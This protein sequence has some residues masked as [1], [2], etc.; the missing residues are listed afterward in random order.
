[1]SPF[2]VII[3]GGGLA[4]SL[5][6]NGLL[7]NGVEVAVYERDAA[8][9]KREGYQIRLGDA[10]DVG[11]KACLKDDVRAAILAKFGQSSGAGNTAPT[12]CNSRFETVLDL[13]QL[14]SYTKSSAINRVAL[15]NILLEPIKTA[16]CVKFQKRLDMYNIVSDEQGNEHVQVRFSDGSTDTCD[17][18]VAADGSGSNVSEISTARVENIVEVD[19]H[20]MFL[21]KGDLTEG[22][23]TKLPSRLRTGPVLTFTKDMTFFFALYLPVAQEQGSKGSSECAYDL[24]RGSFYWGLTVRRTRI[25]EGDPSKIPDL[26]KF[27][28]EQIKNWAPEYRAMVTAGSETGQTENLIVAPLR[29]SKKPSKKWRDDVRKRQAADIN[30]GHPRVWLIGDA[31]HAMQPTRGMGGNQAMQDCADVLQELLR[32]NE[33]AR[34]GIPILPQD[35]ASAAARYEDKMIHRAF[36]WVKKSGGT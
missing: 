28:L 16:G 32:L 20:V 17:I 25:P 5:L 22:L 10:A 24:N 27:C 1:M 18:L 3:V 26:L 36:T 6:A 12:I 19:S 14:P 21:N 29:A 13:T 7:N 23:I 34:S 11:F 35:I 4:G 31:I 8:D 2:K 30:K 15:R 9:S 33:T